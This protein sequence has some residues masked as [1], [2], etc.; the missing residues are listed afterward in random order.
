[1]HHLCCYVDDVDAEVSNL[2]A[3]GTKKLIGTP[4]AFAYLNSGPGG[5]IFELLKRPAS[6]ERG[7]KDGRA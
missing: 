2:V 5:V 6:V 3:Q 1:L 4:G 7:L